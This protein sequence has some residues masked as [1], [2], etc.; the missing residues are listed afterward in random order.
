VARDLGGAV[1]HAHEG[2]VGQQRD[3]HRRAVRRVPT[4]T[5]HSRGRA[6]SPHIP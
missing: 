5:R 3:A 2:G 1:H 4:A 6:A